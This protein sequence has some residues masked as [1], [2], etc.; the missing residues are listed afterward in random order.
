MQRRGSLTV[1]LMSAITNPLFYPFALTVGTLR[2]G[3][4]KFFLLCWA[5]KTVKGIAI[6]HIG[7]FGLG[8]LLRWIGV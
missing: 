8:Y 7:Y 1:F 6:A 2:F 5:G 4:A 3:L